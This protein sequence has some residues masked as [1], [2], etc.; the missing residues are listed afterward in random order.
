MDSLTRWFDDEIAGEDDEGLV[1]QRPNH[2]N[3]DTL[4]PASA[5]REGELPVYS[6]DPAVVHAT[7][8]QYVAH[9]GFVE[10]FTIAGLCKLSPESLQV[11]AK[12][13]VVLSRPRKWAT[14]NA[15]PSPGATA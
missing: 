9:C 11:L 13:L 2:L 7:A 8:K 5:V 14:S 12:G 4:L 10:L 15:A 6:P 3:Q 1:G